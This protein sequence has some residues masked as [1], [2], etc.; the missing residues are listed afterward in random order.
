MSCVT[1]MLACVCIGTVVGEGMFSLCR[2]ESVIRETKWYLV[3]SYFMY[4]HCS[5]I[6]STYVMLM[7][8]GCLQ[9]M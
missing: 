9:R 7:Y 2:G 3:L 1:G 8:N 5:N 4:I 6:V